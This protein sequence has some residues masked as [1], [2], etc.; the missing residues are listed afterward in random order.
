MKKNIENLFKQVVCGAEFENSQQKG[1]FLGLRPTRS[2][3]TIN[4]IKPS[5]ADK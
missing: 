2:S 3:Q 5:I 4:V 1:H